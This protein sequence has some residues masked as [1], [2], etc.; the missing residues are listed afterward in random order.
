MAQ[1][2]YNCY[3][4]EKNLQ[5]DIVAIYNAS[6]TKIATYTYDAWGKVTCTTASVATTM[7]LPRKVVRLN[8]LRL[9]FRVGLSNP[10]SATKESTH[11]STKTMC[12]FFNEICPAG[13]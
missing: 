13:K 6:G 12:A 10:T 2:V 1:G 9:Y 5:G 7:R 8:R 3:F 11:L 4:F